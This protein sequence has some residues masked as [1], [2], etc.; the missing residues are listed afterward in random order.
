MKPLVTNQI[1]TFLELVQRGID[2]WVEAAKI[3]RAELATD[4]EW[5]DKVAEKNRIITAQFVHRF[6][7]IGVKFIPQLAISECPGAKRLRSLPLQVQEMCFHNP[8]SLLIN[9][10]GN[11]EPLQVDLHNLTSD[12]AAQVFAE[13][14]VRNDGEQ[15][16][17]I[18]DR[19]AK[20]AT[21][22]NKVNQP[23]RV[24]GNNLMVMV[25]CKFTRKELAQILASME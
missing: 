4:P 20:Q 21:E 18:E 14:H 19:K 12:Q 11:W 5:A 10:G 8:V 9:N 6:A 3:A 13:D 22:P 1:D 7:S 25:A 16:A 17:W 2:S 15:R 24:V 23:Y